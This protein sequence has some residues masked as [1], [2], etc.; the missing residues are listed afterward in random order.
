MQARL[1]SLDAEMSR[2]QGKAMPTMA[3]KTPLASLE[4]MLSDAITAA[5]M[6]DQPAREPAEV[7]N[8]VGHW[9]LHRPAKTAHS[10][11]VRKVSEEDVRAVEDALQ[12]GLHHVLQ[13]MAAAP[14]DA[15]RRA[16]AQR[17]IHSTRSISAASQRWDLVAEHVRSLAT[18]HRRS[19]DA[20]ILSSEPDDPSHGLQQQGRQPSTRKLTHQAS[21]ELVQELAKKKR[22]RTPAE[23]WRATLDNVREQ[24]L[25]EPAMPSIPQRQISLDVLP[26]VRPVVP[27]RAISRE[28]SMKLLGLSR[29]SSFGDGTG[30]LVADAIEVAAAAAAALSDTAEAHEVAEAAAPSASSLRS[31][32]SAGM[33]QTPS[34]PMP[35][36][37]KHTHVTL[38]N[39]LRV[40]V[41]HNSSPSH[42]VC[43]QLSVAVG[44]LHE[45]E[46]E[47]GIAHLV[48]HLLFNGSHGFPNAGQVEATMR[49]LGCQMGADVNAT[50][51]FDRT[52]FDLAI[53]LLSADCANGQSV[54]LDRLYLALRAL[55]SMC[56]Q[57]YFRAEDIA[58]ERSVVIEEWRRSK[59]P[60]GAVDSAAGGERW[61]GL[62]HG[63]RLGA[64]LPIGLP[65]VVVGCPDEVVRGFYSKW[66]EP[67]RC[68][69]I[70]V[71]DLPPTSS[72][73]SV[74]HT[75]RRGRTIAR[76]TGATSAEEFAEAK[77][78]AAELDRELSEEIRRAGAGGE[79][80]EM[81]SG[82]ELM[83]RLV[84]ACFDDSL[85]SHEDHFVRS[86]AGSQTAAAPPTLPPHIGARSGGGGSTSPPMPAELVAEDG[87][88][89]ALLASEDASC[90]SPSL[91]INFR[92][93]VKP[94]VTYEDMRAALLTMTCTILFQGYLAGVCS[95]QSL[96]VVRP[97]GTRG[98]WRASEMDHI[99]LSFGMSDMEPLTLQLEGCTSQVVLTSLPH[100]AEEER[101]LATLEGAAT[102]APLVAADGAVLA[103]ASHVFHALAWWREVGPSASDVSSILEMF[104]EKLLPMIIEKLSQQ[105]S[106]ELIKESSE[107]CLRGDPIT[108]E[109]PKDIERVFES[110]TPEE[111]IAQRHSFLGAGPLRACDTGTHETG[112][113]DGTEGVE[114]HVSIALQC[115]ARSADPAAWGR[116]ATAA[117]AA[118]WTD[119][120]A[121]PN[122]VLRGTPT[123]VHLRRVQAANEAVMHSF[124]GGEKMVDAICADEP[125][126][127]A[128]GFGSVCDPLGA[129]PPPG[130]LTALSKAIDMD[131]QSK[132][133]AA[134]SELIKEKM[135]GWDEAATAAPRVETTRYKLSNGLTAHISDVR[136]A[137][138]D[139]KMAKDGSGLMLSI[140]MEAEGLGTLDILDALS[141]LQELRKQQQQQQVQPPP[142]AGEGDGGESVG[143]EASLRSR[144]GPLYELAHEATPTQ[145]AFCIE[146]A[147]GVVA[148]VFACGVLEP[149]HKAELA[150]ARLKDQAA[151]AAGLLAEDGTP[152][153][154]RTP[155]EEEEEEEEDSETVGL[156]HVVACQ[157]GNLIG[158]LKL[159]VG[160]LKRT[161]QIET[162]PPYHL[163]LALRCLH[164]IFAS[165]AEGHSALLSERETSLR[166]ILETEADQREACMA[167]PSFQHQAFG[168]A[169]M[170]SSLGADNP[171]VVI[172]MGE[173]VELLRWLARHPTAL[174][175]TRR[176]FG[177]LFSLDGAWSDL[178][179]TGDLSSLVAD[180]KDGAEEH[181]E[182]LL[183]K[184]I[185]SIPP[186]GTEGE[187]RMAGE[188][189]QNSLIR[190]IKR[191]MEQQKTS[192]HPRRRADGDEG[193]DEGTA[194]DPPLRQ[195]VALYGGDSGTAHVQ[196]SFPLGPRLNSGLEALL[197]HF[198]YTV[199]ITCA[200]EALAVE[201]RERLAGTYAVQVNSISA[202]GESVLPGA[203]GIAFTCASGGGAGGG[204][205]ATAE[206]ATAT[207]RKLLQGVGRVLLR[208][209]QTGPSDRELRSAIRIT[210]EQLRREKSSVTGMIARMAVGAQGKVLP[211]DVERLCAAWLLGWCHG[212][213]RSTAF[214][215][216]FKLEDRRGVIMLPSAAAPAPAGG[217]GG[218]LWEPHEWP[219]SIGDYV[220][221]AHEC[222]E[223]AG[224]ELPLQFRGQSTASRTAAMRSPVECRRCGGKSGGF[225]AADGVY[226]ET[227][228]HVCST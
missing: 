5:Y 1:D 211:Q 75:I 37:D 83:L 14:F 68:Q 34:G 126:A 111:V 226:G 52:T 92:H 160:P 221:S 132:E 159:R 57:A 156:R 119:A 103:A 148:S 151:A 125:N 45:T 222:S 129:L 2:I 58:H 26:S 40:L 186:V 202:A 88:R 142:Q 62:L 19:I 60:D 9:L 175:V 104:K 49:D 108:G 144:L 55:A 7:I 51:T 141:T 69:L 179:I 187:Q 176:L 38:P 95:E 146:M 183:G 94:C 63:T 13:R 79:E 84:R 139:Q 227:P 154:D 201:L 171:A 110:I 209:Q 31:S 205:G 97:G 56:F 131:E 207:P 122:E 71:G 152:H 190:A 185:G 182:L 210:C 74:E 145:C 11:R 50:T 3:A 66:F 178:R 120:C 85:G 216:I 87:T 99:S 147:C 155:E 215:A 78:A 208:L 25:R 77:K 214:S 20:S 35:L 143:L 36:D 21:R 44:S 54:W 114:R 39:G 100:K 47:R 206:Q 212:D 133:A 149:L 93:R 213:A 10:V 123:V 41:R 81:L 194:A 86:A 225:I 42:E 136:G 48:E 192:I 128:V 150:A 73:L 124:G 118:A 130:A 158:Q 181:L 33:Q 67:A 46:E 101:L 169:A 27:P 72:A 220:A 115:P 167:L 18:P 102:A 223:E 162:V 121:M 138:F 61:Q 164:A 23:R 157:V 116:C 96:H 180:G 189:R 91:E 170:R 137:V 65:E 105:D 153:A 15:L 163:A 199:V 76:L 109:D 184:F 198:V 112:G 113:L 90:I 200:Q 30:A 188:M 53:P 224:A 80:E 168:E 127:S 4:D 135:G 140:E 70:V 203:T 28:P 204:K 89:F 166:D 98:E 172:P 197:E 17:L 173:R 196:L 107:A 161:L 174:G 106:R 16:V 8:F 59:C 29:S 165:S 43:V 228:G 6:E 82:E 195:H 219:E 134:A 24:R 64:R 22:A 32:I 177:W 191:C 12:A 193:T 218:A 117:L 217:D